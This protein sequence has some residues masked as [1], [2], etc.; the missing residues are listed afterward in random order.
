M[1]NPMQKTS[2]VDGAEFFQLGYVTGNLDRAMAMWRSRYAVP[3]FFE[4]SPRDFPAPEGTAVPMRVA[5]GYQGSVMIELIE[6]DPADA[7]LYKGALRSDG[8][9]KLHHLG[10]LVDEG[11]FA[12][13]PKLIAELG[14]K[15][16][17]VHDS[18]ELKVLYAD[19]REDCGLFT[20]IVG[21]SA[22]V[23]QMFAN[24]P[25]SSAAA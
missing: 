2:V 1:T 17:Y 23:L 20:E 16:P 13:Y 21:R 5:L 4:F 6:P 7:G 18:D 10:Y 22:A 8:G 11:T 24:I 19:T 12:N 3:G 14:I 15:M 9:T 25:R